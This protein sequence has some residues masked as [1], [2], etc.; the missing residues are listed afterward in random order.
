M[1]EKLLATHLLALHLVGGTGTPHLCLCVD[2]FL[3]AG[4]FHLYVVLTRGRS[5]DYVDLDLLTSLRHSRL[6]RFRVRL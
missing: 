4:F 6:L 5:R 2:L 1:A 3:L